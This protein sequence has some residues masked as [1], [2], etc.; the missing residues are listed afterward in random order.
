[1]QLLYKFKVSNNSKY[2]PLPWF[3]QYISREEEDK[4]ISILTNLG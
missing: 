2:F 1:M 4:N 3:D